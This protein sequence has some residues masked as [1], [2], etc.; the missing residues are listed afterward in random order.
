MNTVVAVRNRILQLCGERNISINKLANICGLPPSSVKNILYGKSQNPKVL[1][2]KMICDG[3]G[4]TLAQSFD[5]DEF[6]HLEQEIR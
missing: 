1:T 5:T 4:I 2:I 6:D 3:L